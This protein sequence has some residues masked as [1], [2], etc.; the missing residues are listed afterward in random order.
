MFYAFHKRICW[1]I[2]E[3]TVAKFK[4]TEVNHLYSEQLLPTLQEQFK[5]FL[6]HKYWTY[7]LGTANKCLLAKQTKVNMNFKMLKNIAKQVLLL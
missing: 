2:T 6:N 1:Q 4:N 3:H 5:V 7:L